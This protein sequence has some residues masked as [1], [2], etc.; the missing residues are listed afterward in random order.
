MSKD[1]RMLTKGVH[2]HLYVAFMIISMPCM[3]Q[4]KPN[5]CV[6]QLIVSDL[7]YGDLYHTRACS[8]I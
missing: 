8:H 2:F 3:I 4:L 6:E 7:I 1:Q 5:S